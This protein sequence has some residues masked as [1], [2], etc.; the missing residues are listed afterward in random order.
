MNFQD[1]ATWVTNNKS[2]IKGY[3]HKYLKFSPY[4][5]SDYLREAFEAAMIATVRCQEKGIPFEAAFWVIFRSQINA[6]T[7]HPD[8]TKG[9]NSVPSY[10]TDDPRLLFRVPYQHQQ[11]PDIEGLYHYVSQLL[12]DKERT[13][14]SLSLGLGD[15]GR[16]TLK[17]IAQRLGCVES[18]VRDILKRGLHR[19][20]TMVRSGAITLPEFY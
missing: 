12:T 6:I 19:I 20:H 17:E 3:I 5:E 4:E 11:Q 1:A 7:P 16:L 2:I 10:C 18:N 8:Y 15:E 14:L 9:S 13:V